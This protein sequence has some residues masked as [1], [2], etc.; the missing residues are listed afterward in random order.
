M[1]DEL[2]QAAVLSSEEKQATAQALQKAKKTEQAFLDVQTQ[3]KKD[4][5]KM[6]KKVCWGW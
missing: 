5:A 3:A 1:L 2:E 4:L 6:K